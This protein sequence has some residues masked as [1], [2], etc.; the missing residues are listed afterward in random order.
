MNSNPQ[1]DFFIRPERPEDRDSVRRIL[2]AAFPT[3]AEADLAGKLEEAG[4]RRVSLVAEREGE[5]VG[6]ILFCGVAI[7]TEW[8][9]LSAL[10]LAPVAV[11][12]ECQGRGIGSELVRQGLDHCRDAGHAIVFVLGEPSFYGRFGFTRGR[13]AGLGCDYQCEAF[14]VLELEPDALEGITGRV[15]YPPPFA[16]R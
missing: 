15:V 3:P 16:G 12:P 6:Q 1:R 14:L 13:A 8:G 2:L 9:R 7:E 5:V 4:F 11:A 10:A